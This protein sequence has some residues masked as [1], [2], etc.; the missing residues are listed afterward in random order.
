MNPTVEFITDM[1]RR[2]KQFALRIVKLYQ[3]LPLSGEA[4]VIGKQLLRSG[5]SV[6]ANYRAACRARSSAEF[7]SKL[8][9]VIEEADETSFWIELLQETEIV[10]PALL[11]NL[12]IEN[13]ELVK[14]MVTARKHIQK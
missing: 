14:I 9:I 13:E 12:Y 10:K 3:S 5:T 11:H 2:T 6:G 4:Q 7:Y 8:S 1:K